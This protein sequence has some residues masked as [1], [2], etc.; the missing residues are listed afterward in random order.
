MSFVFNGGFL[1]SRFT[2]PGFLFDDRD[3][4]ALTAAGTVR[5]YPKHTLLIQEGDR[6]DQLYVVLSGRL[7]VF[8]SD[9][10]GKEI[11]IDTLGPNF[12]SDED[13]SQPSARSSGHRSTKNDR[14]R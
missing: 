2:M 14:P 4:E 6:S 12:D 8:L 13:D 1:E 11:V 7:Q 5:S 10:D 3:L 9:S